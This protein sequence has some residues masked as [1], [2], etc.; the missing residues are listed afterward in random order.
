MS[1]IDKD[2]KSKV[3]KPSDKKFFLGFLDGFPDDKKL[4]IALILNKSM[5]RKK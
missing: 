4:L 5:R 1:S 3:S 2:P